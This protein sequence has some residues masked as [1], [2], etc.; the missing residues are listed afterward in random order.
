[1]SITQESFGKTATGTPVSLFTLS[2]NNGMTVKITNYGGAIVELY[3]PDRNGKIADVVLGYDNVAG[4]EAGE[5]YFGALIGRCGNRLNSGVFQLDG[6]AYQLV[7]NEMPKRNTHLHGGRIGFNRVVWKAET[8]EIGSN[9]VLTL[10]YLSRHGEEGYPGNLSVKA[11]YTLT[12]DNRLILEFDASTDA[13]TIVNLTGHTYFNLAGHNSGPINGHEMKINASR[14]T[15]INSEFLPTGEFRT[16]RN[17]PFDFQTAKPIGRDIDRP[18]EQLANGG[19]YDHNFI[20]DR[21]SAD[22]LDAAATVHE[23]GTGRVME[24]FTTQPGVQF[25]SGNF[26]ADNAGKKG[27]VYPWRGG[28]C[29]EPQ[30]FPDAPHHAHFPSVELRPGQ[31]YNHTIIYKFSVR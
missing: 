30:H 6:K 7:V 28:F 10:S 12:A 19:G 20:I 27:A 24:V 21:R 3:I 23:P 5:D 15:P 8:S 9:S 29:L 18:G 26:L 13:P 16:V 11:I 31:E 2:N 22:S 17:S 4:Y 1:M 14:F 25:Y